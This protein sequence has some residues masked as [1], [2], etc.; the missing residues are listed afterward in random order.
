[1]TRRIARWVAITAA[2]TAATASALVFGTVGWL[3]II[4]QIGNR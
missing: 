1:M 3:W 4:E 2:A